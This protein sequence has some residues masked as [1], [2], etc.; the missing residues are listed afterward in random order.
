MAGCRGMGW[1]TASSLKA[2]QHFSLAHQ[3]VNVTPCLAAN[4]RSVV[5]TSHARRAAPICSAMHSPVDAGNTPR[6]QR[7]PYPR[8]R[9]IQRYRYTF[10]W[11]L[12]KRDRSCDQY[13]RSKQSCSNHAGSFHDALLVGITA[14][15]KLARRSALARRQLLRSFRA[16]P[17]P[18]AAALEGHDGKNWDHEIKRSGAH[19]GPDATYLGGETSRTMSGRIPTT[20]FDRYRL[21]WITGDTG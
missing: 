8:F 19:P 18:L 15:M 5:I 14:F 17:V 11:G 10:V 3:P 13:C 9:R 12:I 7:P 2:F 21:K 4:P 1:R 16:A 20:P 6:G